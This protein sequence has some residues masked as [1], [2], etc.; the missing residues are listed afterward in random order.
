MGFGVQVVAAQKN[1]LDT[2]GGANTG[3]VQGLL[4]FSNVNSLFT[5]GNAFA[6]FLQGNP[7]A[8]QQ[9]SAQLKYYGRYQSVEP[10]LQDDWRAWPRL[11]FNLGIR[12]NIFGSWHEK[13]LNAYN[14]VPTVYNPSTAAA[15]NS[16]WGYL[17]NSTTGNPVPLD[18]NNLDLSIT[19]GLVQ[20]GKNG[21]P[22]SCAATHHGI[23]MLNPAP[24]IGFA[25]DVTGDGMTSMR[26]G[27]GI[28]FFHGTG[29]EANTG[30]LEGSAPAVLSMTQSYLP[31]GWECIGGAGTGCPNPGVAYPLNVTSIPTQTVWPYVQ[32]W[33]FSI[34]RQLPGAMVGSIAYVGSKGTHLVADLQLN[35]LAPVDRTDNPFAVGEPITSDVCQG[36]DGASFANPAVTVGQPG[37]SNLLAACY[38]IPAAGSQTKR[39][40][41][42]VN[43][44]RSF[45][46]GLGE[47]FG[48]Q[49]VANSRYNALQATLR[50]TVGRLNLSVA[51]TL[52]RSTDDSSDRFDA[53][54]VNS[55]DL[56]SNYAPSNFDQRQLLNISYI[57]E[58]PSL[59]SFGK[60]LR[61]FYQSDQQ[62]NQPYTASWLMH[63][64]FDNWEFSGITTAQTG[65]PFSVI[66]G[67]SAVNGVSVLDNAGVANG[68][69]AGS[70]PDVI[71][72]TN[73]K[74]P[75]AG[76][77]SKSFGP[78]LANPNAFAAPRGLT[79]GDAGRNALRNPSRINFDMALL[80]HFK[81]TESATLELR[82][83][84]FNVFNHTQLELF[85]PNRGN[86]ASNV[87]SC[88][89]G[90]DDDAGFVGGGVNCLVGNGFLHP[91]DA[92]RPRTIQ[93]GAK[94]IF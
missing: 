18:L 90:P 27:Y 49:N 62:L 8:Y 17:Q 45:A 41:P 28:F 54:L 16:Q 78:I 61:P 40:F 4:S 77:N 6:D 15:V 2:G 7:Q 73:T 83:E 68:I 82:G 36:W 11:A 13:G 72:F 52:G 59:A 25:W 57:Y 44:L 31:S 30:S 87:I 12:F 67:G 81:L 50:R 58:L 66:N 3:D 39:N 23:N 55:F 80:K 56:R 79:F 89:G 86:T 69:G 65:T 46:P 37:Y 70:Y 85:N 63:K 91:V 64:L 53:T 9:D 71:T 32:Q 75:A 48:L 42:N 1:E 47:I 14:W 33:S 22:A 34:Q 93:F 92:H 43:T 60:I 24:R 29:N 21:V 76:N 35:Q 84:A 94:L 51:Y 38:G 10:Y 74:P 5:S 20:C 26:A 19:N 88:Y